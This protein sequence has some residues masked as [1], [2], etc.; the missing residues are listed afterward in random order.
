LAGDDAVDLV[1][2]EC[3]CPFGARLECWAACLANGDCFLGAVGVLEQLVLITA[4]CTRQ[5]RDA[6][7]RLKQ[8]LVDQCAHAAAASWSL[9]AALLKL[10]GDERNQVAE[11]HVDVLAE[12]VTDAFAFRY[13]D[14]AE[15]RVI[16]GFGVGFSDP[17]GDVLSSAVFD[18]DAQTL[19]TDADPAHVAS[20]LTAVAAAA[21]DA[22][23]V[24][25]GR[26]RGSDG[27][28]ETSA[29]SPSA[30]AGAAH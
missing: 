18:L 26:E 24:E 22:V 3:V 11:F 15:R 30:A 17:S 1:V 13:D 14:A 27:G 6:T 21:F 10:P 4:S 20:V 7:E 16:T 9:I 19:T 12:R 5:A 8:V 2:F 28:L 29:G 23:V 25:G